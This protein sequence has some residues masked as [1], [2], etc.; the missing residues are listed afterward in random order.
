M[1]ILLKRAF[2]LI[3]TYTIPEIS[4]YLIY[5]LN[6][7]QQNFYI[8]GNNSNKLSHDPFVKFKNLKKNIKFKFPGQFLANSFG[9]V[10]FTRL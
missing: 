10:Y 6:V 3:L 4:I 2:F 8:F 9:R 5:L 1:A 7:I